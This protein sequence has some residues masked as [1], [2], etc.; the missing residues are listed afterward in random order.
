MY[1]VSPDYLNTV[2]SKTPHH[3]LLSLLTRRRERNNSK[4]PRYV[5]IRRDVNVIGGLQSAPRRDVDVTVISGLKYVANFTRQMPKE[6]DR[7]ADFLKYYQPP[8]RCR[9]MRL[10]R[11]R[12]NEWAH[13]IVRTC[14]HICPDLRSEISIQTTV[15]EETVTVS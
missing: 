1:L 11:I 9:V 7:L 10:I 2:T 4:R 8:Q 12:G 3:R 5:K 13:W 15:S 6:T 14:P